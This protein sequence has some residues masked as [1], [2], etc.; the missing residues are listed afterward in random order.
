MVEPLRFVR[1]VVFV[2]VGVAGG[3]RPQGLDWARKVSLRMPS[4]MYTKDMT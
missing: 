2:S 4:R 1:L 3:I